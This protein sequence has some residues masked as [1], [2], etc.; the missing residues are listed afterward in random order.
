MYNLTEREVASK[1]GR[2]MVL[3]FMQVNGTGGCTKR[4]EDVVNVTSYK[5]A[6]VCLHP[7]FLFILSNSSFTNCSNETCS[8]SQCWNTA[9]Y[10]RAL[11]ARVPRWVPVP[12]E[13]PSTMTLFRHKRDFG[14]TALVV[15]AMSAIAVS[16]T[17]AAI[18]MT[19]AVQTGETLN[20]L[21][22]AVASALE[23]Q[24]TM[25]AH[26]KGGLMVIN[27]RIDLVQ[28]Q[29]D[30]L[31]QL[32]QLGCEWKLD[33]LCIT[34]VQYENFTR[35]ANLSR[36]LSLYL[37][38]NWSEDFDATLED[39]RHA[40]VLINSTRVDLSLAKGLQSWISSALSL[41]K[42]WVGV[43]MFFACCIGGCVLCLWLTC[44]LRTQVSRDKAV[45]LQALA[46]LEKGNSPQVWL[47][48]LRSH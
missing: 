16:A 19:T 32:A 27:Q 6:P 44:H 9:K 28:E 1:A 45:V 40:I 26:I 43:G 2:G 14:V 47:S 46:A 12:V 17:T 21:S 18:A 22:T 5:A 42:E 3:G 29:V 39:L 31:W 15:V 7:P 11:V 48:A 35:A 4:L 13:A 30:I 33:A 20:R 38:G 37:A 36:S 10:T 25:D 24:T 23:K 8:L 34:S 41:F